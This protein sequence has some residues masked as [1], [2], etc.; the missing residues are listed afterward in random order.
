[1]EIVKITWSDTHG[2]AE[3]WVSPEEAI[4]ITP[5][6]MVTVGYLVEHTDQSVTIAGTMSDCKEHYG[7]INCIPRGCVKNIVPLKVDCG[8][9]CSRKEDPEC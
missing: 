2:T 8:F 7:N 1:M 4:A 9:L 6:D 5:I 3:P